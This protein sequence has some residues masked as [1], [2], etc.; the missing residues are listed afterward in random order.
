MGKLFPITSHPGIKR[1]GTKFAGR[2]Y[3]DGQW[4]RFQRGLPRKM[5]GY[6][7]IINTL[8]SVPR[9]IFVYPASPYFNIFVG[10]YNSLL[11]I[12]IDQDGNQIGPVHDRTPVD[13]VASPDNVWTF[14]VM[15]SSIS[16]SSVIIAQAT[17]S[18][19]SITTA[20]DTP[21]FY[22]P[23]AETTPLIPTGHSVS[24]GFVVLH[25]HLFI[26]GNSGGVQWT[27]PNNP[28][29]IMD[30][31][32]VTAQKIV[33]GLAT[34][35]GNSSPAGLLWSLDSLIRVTQVSNTDIV[36]KFD[37]VSNQSSILSS[38]SVTEYDGLYFWAGIDHFLVYNGTVQ[39]VPNSMNMNF[40]FNK[41]LEK[42]NYAQRQKVFATKVPQFGEIWYFYPSGNNTECDRAIIFNKRENSWYDTDITRSCGY[43]EQVFADPIWADS[44]PNGNNQYGLWIHE[45]GVDQNIFGALSAIESHFTTGDI[46]WCASGPTGSWTGEDRWVNLERLE[47]DF[48]QVGDMSVV[49][50]GRQYA[51]GA[52][53]ASNPYI[54]TPDTQ[55]IDFR[56]QRREMSLTFSSNEVGGFYEMGQTLLYVTLGDGRA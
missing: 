17:P 35:G 24:G 55:K 40:F 38:R 34:R 3:N 41:P 29:V 10:T 18:L 9:G 2:Y 50:Q 12:T 33:T 53:V 54:F 45:S 26:F 27:E 31:A 36:F 28:I 6:K 8:A 4:C 48:I 47:P 11:M 44:Q 13:L 49:V 21:I 14:D 23:V 16:D 42:L 19:S 25:P 7:Q 37:T 52:D 20:T 1:D 39:E 32:R 51:R 30:G 15:Y 46:A 5:G 43:F 56:E 22:G